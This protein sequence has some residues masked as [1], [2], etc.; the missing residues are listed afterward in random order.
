M[1]FNS[2]QAFLEKLSA[3]LHGKDP[4]YSNK[5]LSDTEFVISHYAGDVT[6][7]STGFNEK[8]K[9][10]LHSDLKDL[11]NKCQ[12]EV[13]HGLLSEAGL[14]VSM[15]LPSGGAKPAPTVSVQ[16]SC[17]LM[18]PFLQSLY[19]NCIALLSLVW[20][21]FPIVLNIPVVFTC[22]DDARNA[23]HMKTINII[24][25]SFGIR[26]LIP[27]AIRTQQTAFTDSED[28]CVECS[29]V[30][31]KDQLGSLLLKLS[32]TSVN[33]IRCI[34]SNELKVADNFDGPMVLRQLNYS[35]MLETVRVCEVTLGHGQ[36]CVSLTT[37]LDNLSIT[38]MRQSLRWLNFEQ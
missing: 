20:K 10:T 2:L 24:I 1:F 22:M 28:F 4:Y 14:A 21:T 25:C 18:N 11:L 7:D 15:T 35:G 8:N 33:Y 17:N 19:F 3:T 16:V 23:M 37:T 31:F 9:D 26:S 32:A 38:I 6:Y 34:K 29:F 5:R 30:Q 36:L 27:N 12:S 13:L